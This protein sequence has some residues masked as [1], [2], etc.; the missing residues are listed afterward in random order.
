M[1][2]IN[3][4]GTVDFDHDGHAR[5]GIA[6]QQARI[7]KI[8]STKATRSLTKEVAIERAASVW[9][10]MVRGVGRSPQKSGLLS[11]QSYA[12]PLIRALTLITSSP[13]Q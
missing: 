4:M 1:D 10:C 13:A 7:S 3:T 12:K 9:R 2:A 11:E 5:R 8:V 6:N